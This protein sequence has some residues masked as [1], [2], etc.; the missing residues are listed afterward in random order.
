MLTLEPVW[1]YHRLGYR[2]E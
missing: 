1:R 2:G